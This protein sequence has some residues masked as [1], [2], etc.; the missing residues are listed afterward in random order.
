MLTLIAWLDQHEREPEHIDVRAAAEAVPETALA[1]TQVK[2]GFVSQ[3][4]LARTD[5]RFA[6]LTD[7]F[8][9][10]LLPGA[11]KY[12]DLPAFLSRVRADK[13]ITE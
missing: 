2:K 11:V 10:R 7:P 8:D 12:G 9:V 4:T 1:L 3:V 13:V 6:A 5:F